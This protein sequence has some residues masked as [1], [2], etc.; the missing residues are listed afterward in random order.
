MDFWQDDRALIFKLQHPFESAGLFG[1]TLWGNGPYRG[2]VAPLYPLWLLF[3]LNP[4][5]YFASSIVV[6]F[7][8]TLVIFWLGKK[9]FER[10][11]LALVMAS[12]FAA[13]HLGADGMLRIINSYQNLF[14][15]IGAAAT[16]GFLL[17]HLKTRNIFW[18]FLSLIAFIATLEVVF[19]RSGG[20]I[21]AVI[22]AD[23]LFAPLSLTRRGVK[24]FGLLIARQ[25]PFIL[26]FNKIY[27]ATADPQ[28]SITTFVKTVIG[29]RQFEVLLTPLQTFGSLVV[30]DRLIE[31]P[32]TLVGG[33]AV[34]AILALALLLWKRSS[35]LA[36]AILWGLLTTFA[37]F[38]PNWIQYP[39]EAFNTTHR[40][41]SG[42]LIG[43]YTI[44][45][46]VVAL[47]AHSTLHLRRIARG[48]PLALVAGVPVV[49]F[50]TLNLHYQVGLL[51]NR[52]QPSKRFYRQLRQLVPRFEKGS[53]I[54]FEVA[55]DPVN[56]QQFRDFFAVGSMPDETA[57]AIYYG[58]DRYDLTLAESVDELLSLAVTNQT[59]FEE[60]YYFRYSNQ[61]LADRS[62]QFRQLVAEGLTANLAGQTIATDQTATFE[63][64]ELT[65]GLPGLLKISYRFNG[66]GTEPLIDPNLQASL[67]FRQ[68]LKA[69]ASSE[70]RFH[71]APNL[72]DNDPAMLWMAHRIHWHDS[73]REEITID[74]GSAR[75]VDKLS[76]LNGHES[77]TPTSYQIEAAQ[78]SGWQALVDREQAPTRKTG[79]LIEERFEPVTTNQL[80]LTIRATSGSDSP[81]I[82]ELYPLPDIEPPLSVRVG[83]PAKRLHQIVAIAPGSRA[84]EF[85]LPAGLPS[86][87]PIVLGPLKPKGTL[88]IDRLELKIPNLAELK[89]KGLVRQ[90]SEN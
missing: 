34:A 51:T 54:Y 48:K 56:Q 85:P 33:I 50:L 14:G 22:A 49:L 31:F 69:K 18:Y 26:A 23:L 35:R 8:A 44:V 27:E 9:I 30:P 67:E 46:A 19:I 87:S 66:S 83:T 61:G 4:A 59:R 12:L 65:A 41:L 75:R 6:Y 38:L 42:S 40:Y 89:A 43:Y 11:D 52:A 39:T 60:L 74:F 82:A 21:V 70:W 15:V 16:I 77:R 28:G 7:L 24:E 37:L 79:E 47:I 3:G 13:S 53:L 78:N 73:Q 63:F 5:P 58:I 64:D 29:E 71:E 32:K 80:K 20:L 17:T 68:A 72:L 25:L 81:Q 45:T 57:I 76:W 90:F 36:R 1:Q 55:S 88:A 84:I 62:T 2:T 86:L 10:D